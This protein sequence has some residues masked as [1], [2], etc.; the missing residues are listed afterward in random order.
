MI[1]H[2][3]KQGEENWKKLRLGIPTA[4]CFGR[5][6]TPKKLGYASGAKAYIYQLL[7]EWYTGLPQDEINADWATY[8]TAMEG[9][10]VR[11]YEFQHNVTVQDVGFITTDDGR[12]GCSPDR[13]IGDDG[14]LEIKCPMTVSKCI[15]FLLGESADEYRAQVQGCLWVTG[16]AWW[17]LVIYHPDVPPQIRRCYPEPE[18]VDAWEQVYPLFLADLDAAKEKL[19]ADGLEEAEI[20][21]GDPDA[22]AGECS[23]CGAAVTV[24][25]RWDIEGA[26]LCGPC[27]YQA[28]TV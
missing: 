16:R 21:L 7:A 26:T 1:V 6:L 28:I 9:E 14:G 18:W 19:R 3:C 4:S 13:L 25:D 10:A 20:G 2:Q 24:A 5:I 8:G 23:D 12:I 17:D 27:Y 15:G 11:W 22:P